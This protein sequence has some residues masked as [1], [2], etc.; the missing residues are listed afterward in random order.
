MHS[1]VCGSCNHPPNSHDSIQCVKDQ[2]GNFASRATACYPP[3][4]AK[5]FASTI[6]PLLT[7]G[8]QDLPWTDLQ[9]YLPIK[10]ISDFPFSQ[11]DGGGNF[12]QADWSRSDRETPDSFSSLRK[13]CLQR[14]ISLR[15]DKMLVA[16]IQSG[17]PDPPFSN[18]QLI[19]FVQD[20]EILL[21][22]HDIRPDWSV[23]EHQPMHLQ[24]FCSSAQNH[25]G[26]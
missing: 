6:A 17:S 13:T 15:M 3:Q 19:P 2:W 26:S 5:A 16:H 24:I 8:P 10:Q 20:L 4:L 1:N 9:Q 14:I 12:S 11:V 18:E 22:Q 7:P 25:G 23:R 21:N